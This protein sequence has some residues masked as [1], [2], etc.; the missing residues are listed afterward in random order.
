MNPIKKTFA[1]FTLPEVRTVFKT[2][3]WPHK[4]IL[5]TGVVFMVLFAML[6]AA[7]VKI[8][9][10]IF[11]ELLLSKNQDMIPIIALQI[12]AIFAFKGTASYI[13]SICMAKVGLNMVQNMQNDL[14]NKLVRQDV[15]FLAKHNS[16]GVLMHF[17]GDMF[18]VRDAV[19]NG[20]TSL[21][22]DSLTVFFMVCLMF[23]KNFEMAAILFF[24]FPLALY[25]VVYLGRKAKRYFLTQQAFSGNLFGLISQAV[26]G[27]K[28]IKS[29]QLEDAEIKNIEKGTASIATL[30]FKLAKIQGIASPLMEFFGGVAM[31]ST[32]MYGGWKI[33]QGTLTTG[34]FMVFLL[35]IVA[36]YKPMKNLAHLNIKV[37]IGVA[38]IGRVFGLMNNDITIKDAPDATNLG[39]VCGKISFENLN[40]SYVK[41]SPALTNV[42]LSIEAGQ[43]VAIV[44]LAG[45]GKSTLINLLMRF[46][47]PEG[48]CILIDGHDINSITLESLYSNIAYVSQDVVLFEGTIL[49]NLK[50]G[51]PTSTEDEIIQAAKKCGAH[52]FIIKKPE[53]Y[54]TEVGERGGNLSGGQ[55]QLVSIVRAMLKDAPIIVMDEPTSSLD[56]NSERM[57]QDALRELMHNRTTL[58]IAHRLSTIRDANLIYVMEAS[59]VIEKGTHA[60]LIDA[61]KRYAHLY[62]LQHGTQ[63]DTKAPV[64][65]NK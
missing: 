27:I 53:G 30:S 33:T 34:A 37:Q 59:E 45:S 23:W 64:K 11:D 56:S 14:F 60:Q 41:D 39:R 49:S 15:S 61:S 58:T 13:Q 62:Q 46:Y 54:L 25:P 3:V 17:M 26:Q 52:E 8:L 9:E 5:L 51:S 22:K 50:I 32:L 1:Q 31:A 44:G 65:L 35:A 28:V 24:L 6:E 7:S 10:P 48:G 38:A 12:L 16:S 20:F 29:Y 4:K 55:K 19:L 36:A 57:V 63:G 40:F 2:Y 21:I 47:E 42:S 43:N 18:M